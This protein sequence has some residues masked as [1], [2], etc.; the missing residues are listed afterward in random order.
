[1][2]WGDIIADRQTRRII[3]SRRLKSFFIIALHSLFLVDVL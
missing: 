1:M 2:E 3:S